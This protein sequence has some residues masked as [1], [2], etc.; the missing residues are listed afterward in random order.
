M[1]AACTTGVRLDR[2]AT[3]DE[4]LAGEIDRLAA[5]AAE[6]NPFYESWCLRPA[7]EHLA[8][9]PLHLLTVRGSG[10]ELLGL[11][12]LT[13]RPSFKRLPQRTLRSWIHESVFLATP[14]LHRDHVH[15]AVEAILDWFA[16]RDGA[17]DVI[18]LVDI[19]MDGVV[20]DALA[21]AMAR[22][23]QLL[24]RRTRW[25]R[26]IHHL[27]APEE[28]EHMSA[29]QRSTLRRKERRMADEGEIQYRSL[30]AGDDAAPWI[31]HFMAVEASGWKGRSGT[32]MGLEQARRDFLVAACH[33]AHARGQLHM[34]ALEV[35]G[36]PI[37]MKCNFTSGAMAFT[38]KIAYD[39]AWAR[40]SPGVLLEL[41]QMRTLRRTHPQLQ[42]V[43][44]CTVA[45]NTMFPNVWPGRCELGDF[46]ILH[47]T[48]VNRL[49]LNQGER[50]HRLLRR[51]A[52]QRA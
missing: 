45:D 42:A 52:V 48:L 31:A 24:S 39:E 22:R 43:D 41:F 18:E 13:L 40:F 20:G 33:A 26:A 15:E 8:T 51:R 32:A 6:P 9:E 10:G 28:P 50:V 4:G 23:P 46:A 34:V 38:F 37:A 16:T 27:D 2:L 49:V 19:R 5:S 12:P 17:V 3:I 7:L 11:L 36:T 44:S 25:T 21:G 29:K 47:N 35:D 14:L 30:S 1:T